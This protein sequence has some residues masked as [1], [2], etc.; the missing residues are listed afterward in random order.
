MAEKNELDTLV[1][2]ILTVLVGQIGTFCCDVDGEP[3]NVD[4]GDPAVDN[5]TDFDPVFGV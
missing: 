2:T 4:F 1:S 3:R 5:L